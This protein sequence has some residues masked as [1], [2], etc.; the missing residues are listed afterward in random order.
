MAQQK[1]AISGK[2]TAN[3]VLFGRGYACQNHPGNLRF[4]KLAERYRLEYAEAKYNEEKSRIVNI[5]CQNMSQ[6]KPP[7]RFLKM[8]KD[9]Q[10][11]SLPN[12]EAEVIAKV[13]QI[14]RINGNVKNNS[15]HRANRDM[16]SVQSTSDNQRTKI[17]QHSASSSKGRGKAKTLSSRS[18]DSEFKSPDM[19]RVLNILKGL[20]EESQK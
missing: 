19:Q 15:L 3:D 20:G 4:R 10:Y 14:L 7:G 12:D 8:G 13:Q 11:Y 18:F 5:L 2:P 1:T 6:L 9:G 17:D 16:K